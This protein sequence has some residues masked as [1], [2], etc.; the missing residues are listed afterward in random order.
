MAAYNAGFRSDL[1]G[2]AVPR[3]TAPDIG[4]YER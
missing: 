4:A 2:V 1:S 3:G